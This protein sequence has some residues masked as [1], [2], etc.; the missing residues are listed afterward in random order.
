MFFPSQI[1]GQTSGHLS[2]MIDRR[3]YSGRGGGSMPRSMVMNTLGS[4]AYFNP[5]QIQQRPGGYIASNPPLSGYPNLGYASTS[6]MGTIGN[7]PMPGTGYVPTYTFRNNPGE[8][9]SGMDPGWLSFMRDCG[10]MD[11][12][13]DT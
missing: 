2:S 8:M 1:E 9:E 6:N 4:E 7:V 10:I 12:T 5:S 13:E 11:V 3:E